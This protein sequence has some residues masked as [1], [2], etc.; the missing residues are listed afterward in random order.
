MLLSNHQLK[1]LRVLLIRKD[2]KRYAVEDYLKKSLRVLL[3][4]KDFKLVAG[5]M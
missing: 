4:R 5:V 1:S 2:F 3:I